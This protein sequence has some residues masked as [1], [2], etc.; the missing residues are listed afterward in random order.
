MLLTLAFAPT[1][2]PSSTRQFGS[3]P[4]PAGALQKIGDSTVFTRWLGTDSK[5]LKLSLSPLT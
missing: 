3:V 5:H 1:S 2:S 4:I